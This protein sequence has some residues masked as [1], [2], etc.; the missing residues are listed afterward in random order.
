MFYVIS[1]LIALL[2]IFKMYVSIKHPFWN[3]Q[4]IF[5]IYNLYY[6]FYRGVIY[7]TYPKVDKKYYDMTVSHFK[8][9]TLTDKQKKNVKKFIKHNW[10]LEKLNNEPYMKNLN[11]VSLFKTDYIHGLI[12][13]ELLK[14]EAA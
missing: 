8:Y 2:V 3:R 1:I 7:K 14:I 4:P 12:G 9:N 6:W 11:Y 13:G 10:T 5:H